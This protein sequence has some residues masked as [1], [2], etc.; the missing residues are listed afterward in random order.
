MG[1]VPDPAPGPTDVLIRVKAAALDRVDVYWREGSHGMRVTPPHIGGRDVAGTVVAVGEAAQRTYPDLV[2]GADVVAI[3]R[4]GTHAELAVVPAVWTLPLPPG[5]SYEEAAA[6]PT[7]GRSAYD[8]LVNR[9]AIR[10]GEDVLIFAGGSGVGSF[11]IQIA[12][13]AGC[14]VI[15]TV[16][17]SE[18]RSRALDL[19]AVAVIDHYR[20]DIVTRI[21]DL[22][23]GAGVHV[24]LDH[25]GAPV[26]AAAI[27]SLR[28]F[29]R[30]VTTGVTAGHL[31]EL[32]LGRVFE[33]G[34]S[35]LGVGRPDEQRVR[36]VLT[37][38]FR[39]VAQGS[40]GPVVHE[41]FPLDRIAEAHRLMESSDFFGKIV[42]SV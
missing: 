19:G 28:P 21:R 9:A 31:A 23:A 5:C 7:A 22:T 11:G 4:R 32:H 40:V 14:R 2:P 3:G 34:L 37:E 24:V 6:V 35:V 1:E 8:A 42:L 27:R 20:E 41:V 16:G 36:Q 39:L 29:G 13:A 10:P 30:Y 15:T 18:K 25:V 17:R 12:R 33:H 38:L 26:F